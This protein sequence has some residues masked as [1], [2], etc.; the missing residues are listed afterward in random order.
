MSI[1]G[2]IKP[3]IAMYMSFEYSLAFLIAD[4][5]S[6][7]SVGSCT[8]LSSPNPPRRLNL[9]GLLLPPYPPSPPASSTF[10]ASFFEPNP[11]V[12]VIFPKNPDTDLPISPM[13]FVMLWPM[14]ESSTALTCASASFVEIFVASTSPLSLPLPVILAKNPLTPLVT[15]WTRVLFCC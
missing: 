9:A 4:G 7:T 1:S 8:T 13:A 15:F 5:T 12:D 10:S 2:V 3:R 6:F 11:S 14:P